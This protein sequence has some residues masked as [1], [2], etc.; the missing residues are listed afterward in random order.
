M[1][2]QHSRKG[3]SLSI[4]DDIA[5][6]SH[7]EGRQSATR[8]DL[9]S[10]QWQEREGGKEAG[11]HVMKPSGILMT[12]PDHLYHGLYPTT[13]KGINIPGSTKGEHLE[14]FL[15]ELL[16]VLAKPTGVEC[17]RSAGRISLHA[18]HVLNTHHYYHHHHRSPSKS[19]K[20]CFHSKNGE[21]TNP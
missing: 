17:T 16:L 9:S 5:D 2:H 14:G 6:W 10:N 4:M 20:T 19:R 7:G 13:L 15:V 11:H 8:L 21:T 1:K 18:C 12:V 3:N